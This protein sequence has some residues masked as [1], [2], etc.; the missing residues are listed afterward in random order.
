[1]QDQIELETP[2]N[3]PPDRVGQGLTN[4]T[5][6]A[7]SSPTSLRGKT[8][9]FLTRHFLKP[10]MLLSVFALVL[11]AIALWPALVSIHESRRATELAKWTAW[12][13]FYE[14]CET[15]SLDPST[16]LRFWKGSRGHAGHGTE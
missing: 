6:P 5:T 9:E 12:K 16:R 8:A 1:M 11:S 4:R 3:S 2:T 14:F 7:T 10:G 13:D 15:V